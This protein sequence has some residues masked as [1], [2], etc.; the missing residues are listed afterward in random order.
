MRTACFDES[1]TLYVASQD[2]VIADFPLPI[3]D[4]GND[5]GARKMKPGR[6]I[7]KGV[8]VYAMIGNRDW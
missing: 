5:G 4:W 2:M 8:N 1:I 7:L 6:V 3:G